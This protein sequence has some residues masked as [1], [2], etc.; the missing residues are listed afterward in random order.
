MMV[1]VTAA[2]ACPS[3]GHLFLSLKIGDQDFRGK[4]Q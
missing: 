1:S 2:M 4:H 3:Q